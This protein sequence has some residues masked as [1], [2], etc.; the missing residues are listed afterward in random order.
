MQRKQSIVTSNVPSMHMI[1]A[2]C[3]N[4][5][6]RTARGVFGIM[7]MGSYENVS[8]FRLVVKEMEQ[9]F[10]IKL[11]LIFHYFLFLISTME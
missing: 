7:Y 2:G 4:I 6:L 8:N 9:K 10:Y 11:W 1:M 5:S 3:L